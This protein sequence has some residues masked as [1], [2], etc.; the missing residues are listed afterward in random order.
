MSMTTTTQSIKEMKEAQASTV[1]GTARP[2]FPS[3]RSMMRSFEVFDGELS[4]GRKRP[5]A[6]RTESDMLIFA[7]EPWW[8]PDHARF[9]NKPIKVGNEDQSGDDGDSGHFTCEAKAVDEKEEEGGAEEE[10]STQARQYS[11]ESLS[12][13][14]TPSLVEDSTDVPS[15][16]SWADFSDLSLGSESG[17]ECHKDEKG[18]G[19]EE[20]EDDDAMVVEEDFG[21]V[22]QGADA[23]EEVSQEDQKVKPW[24]PERMAD[25]HQFMAYRQRLAARRK[26]RQAS[27]ESK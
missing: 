14:Y 10:S 17:R 27:N 21:E 16:P 22:D 8:V 25:L 19:G 9:T 13:A 26:T 24:S 11:Y 18:L 23:A 3:P 2:T 1:A 20:Q 12:S 4:K 5:I 15:Q 6:R 7:R